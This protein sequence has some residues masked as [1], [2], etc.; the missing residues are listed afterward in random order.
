VILLRLTSDVTHDIQ[1]RRIRK[2][3]PGSTIR[4]DLEAHIEGEHRVKT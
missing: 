1:S 2:L 4:V 3:G